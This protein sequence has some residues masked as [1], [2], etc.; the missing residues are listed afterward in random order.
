MTVSSFHTMASLGLHAGT[1]LTQLASAAFL[2]QRE[3]FHNPWTCMSLLGSSLFPR[4]SGGVDCRLVVL[5][6]VFNLH[7]RVSTCHACLSVTG[8]PHSVW[9]LPVPSICLGISRFHYFF[10]LLSKLHCVKIPHF[11]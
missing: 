9:F 3:R 6:S 5:F 4:F 1:S 8:L 10:P 2:S 11:L 7:I